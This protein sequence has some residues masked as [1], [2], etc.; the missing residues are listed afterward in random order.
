[1]PSTSIVSVL[2][3][4]TYVVAGYMA[5]LS[6]LLV[7]AGKAPAAPHT[8]TLVVFPFVNQSTRSD[9][10]WMSEGLAVALSRRVSGPNQYILSLRERN[11][12]YEDVGLVEGPPITL[13]SAY[14]V[15]ETL[16]VDWAVIGTFDVQ[17]SQ[18]TA[19]AR[20]LDVRGLKLYE[21]LVASGGM[22]DFVELETDLAWRMLS[23]H[24]PQKSEAG[25]QSVL[26]L[27]ATYT[28][29]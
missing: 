24:A 11:A 29:I 15:A 2:E 22:A 25:D 19:K 7:L 18:L 12:A 10:A 28:R 8:R 14:R 20:L 4:Q 9:L 27:T 23:E 21:P 17:G 6:A 5:T 16:G 13:A 26:E 1:M 3:G